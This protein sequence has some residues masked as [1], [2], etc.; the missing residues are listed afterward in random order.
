[1]RKIIYLGFD[2]EGYCKSCGTHYDN[3]TKLKGCEKCQYW[4]FEKTDDTEEE[5]KDK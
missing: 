2:E 4:K 1:M 3:V 5:H